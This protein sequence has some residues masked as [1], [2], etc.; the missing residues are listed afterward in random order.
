MVH[1]AFN[2]SMLT[3]CTGDPG[4]I[5]SFEGLGVEYNLSCEK[6]PVEILD[7]QDKRL[8]NKEVASAKGVM[9]ESPT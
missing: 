3:K 8:R 2:V 6:V 4:S 9:E 1:L 5:L 7:L